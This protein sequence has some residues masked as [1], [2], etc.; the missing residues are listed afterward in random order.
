[1]M[2]LLG[3]VVMCEGKGPLIEKMKGMELLQQQA[4]VSHIQQVFVINYY[5]IVCVYLRLGVVVLFVCVLVVVYMVYL[6]CHIFCR[7][8][9]QQNMFVQLTGLSWRTSLN[10]EFYSKTKFLYAEFSL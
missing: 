2:L 10:R 3:C 8:L 4:L 1:M 6:F 5:H 7:S 9:T